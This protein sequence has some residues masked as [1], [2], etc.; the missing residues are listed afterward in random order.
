[1]PIKKKYFSFLIS[2]TYCDALQSN[3][4]KRRKYPFFWVTRGQLMV[5]FY[6]LS[7]Q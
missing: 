6:T 1:M 7:W 5:N 4:S 2:V 3:S